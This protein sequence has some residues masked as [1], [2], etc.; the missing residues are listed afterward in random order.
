MCRTSTILALSLN[1]HVLLGFGDP[2]KVNNWRTFKR[3][4]TDHFKARKNMHKKVPKGA[5][6]IIFTI[7]TGLATLPMKFPAILSK[8]WVKKTRHAQKFAISKKSTNFVQSSWN[9]VKMIAICVNHFYQISW[10]LDKNCDFFFTNGQFFN[11]GPF[12]LPRP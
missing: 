3:P 4:L 1:E 5:I 12:L 9:L 8:V 6:V 10:G 2:L 7:K 11:V